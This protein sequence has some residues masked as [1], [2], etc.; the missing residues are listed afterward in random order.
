MIVTIVHNDTDVVKLRIQEIR[1]NMDHVKPR[2]TFKSC[3]VWDF[4]SSVFEESKTVL[5]LISKQNKGFA[6]IVYQ[7]L[8][9]QK[10]P[11]T[12]TKWRVCIVLEAQDS[13][14]GEEFEHLVGT[15]HVAA[16]EELKDT[17]AWLPKVCAFLFKNKRS[18][19][20]P[21]CVFP[22]V[23][24]DVKL[25]KLR[26]RIKVGLRDLGLNFSDEVQANIPRCCILLRKKDEA[27][28][29]KLEAKTDTIIKTGGTV[30]EYSLSHDDTHDCSD[31]HGGSDTQDVSDTHN[32]RTPN[33]VN[34]GKDSPVLFLLH[35]LHV[36]GVIK[37]TRIREWKAPSTRRKL[38][39]FSFKYYGEQKQSNLPFRI[40]GLAVLS[41]LVNP[42]LLLF[43][44]TPF[45]YI[46]LQLCMVR[47]K[48]RYWNISLII[49][50]VTCTTVLAI[51]ILAIS[52]VLGW[53]LMSLA[54]ILVYIPLGITA[55]AQIR[56]LLLSDLPVSETPAPV[57]PRRV[58]KV[59]VRPVSQ[60]ALDNASVH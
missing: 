34:Y 59:R 26:E 46:A 54:L 36:L 47:G 6:K 39:S 2:I 45:P 60:S 27:L 23:S 24:D 48:A 53:G 57:R 55:W 13:N 37:V 49:W 4:Q 10:E 30:I 1:Q 41:L 17:F 33:K 38:S 58:Q 18:D 44:L 50:M 11:N 28:D 31:T 15:E 51:S 40:C 5:V 7:A 32:I 25:N 43:F 16:V 12:G 3:C 52:L 21:N 9:K 20:P 22:K 8:A 29:S 42:S 19:S 35:V 56:Y 14:T